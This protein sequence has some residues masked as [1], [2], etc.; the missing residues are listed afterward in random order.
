MKSASLLKMG[1][2]AAGLIIAASLIKNRGQ[3]DADTALSN[4]ALL[5]PALAKDLNAVTALDVTAAGNTKI[6]SLKKTDAGWVAENLNNYPG[7]VN[8]VREY[9]IKLSQA[10]IRESKTAHPDAYTKLGVEDLKTDGAKGVMI[11]LSGLDKPV[12]LI[13]G[14]IAGAGGEGVYVRDPAQKQSYLASGAIRPE[15]SINSWI[16]AEITNIGSSRI[17]KVSITAPDGS[18]LNVAKQKPEEQDWAV[19]DPPK[20]KELSG[21]SAGNTVT[22]VLDQLRLETVQPAGDTQLDDK[23]LYTAVYDT[24]DGVSVTIKTWQ[25]DGKDVM[26]VSA[27]FNEALAQS[28]AAAESEKAKATADA[29]AKATPSA[30]APAFD[31]DKFKADKVAALRKEVDAI[32]ARTNGW[33]YTVPPYQFGNIKKQMSDMLKPT[34]TGTPAAGTPG[35]PL[36]LPL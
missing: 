3:G 4:D 24:F 32:N 26:R 28:F 23:S 5:V 14:A 16:Q 31:A 2:L 19:L 21:P 10:K 29:E 13:M 17:Q 12:Q 11:T 22:G 15:A 20:G 36:N 9:L 35:N 7:D 18:V 30:K 8:K 6:V 34:E 25:L 1:A 27:S 33:N